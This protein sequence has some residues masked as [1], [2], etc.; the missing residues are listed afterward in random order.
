MTMLILITGLPGTGKTTLAKALAEATGTVHFNSDMIREEL[1]KKG[2]YR[3]QTKALIY[4]E[5]LERTQAELTT[6][7]TVIVDA[8]FSLANARVAFEAVAK[9]LKTPI[10]WIQIQADEQ[11]IKARVSQRRAHSEADFVVYNK[12]K[13]EYQPLAQHH[14][15]LWST[16]DN[17]KEMVRKAMYYLSLTPKS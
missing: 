11:Q 15:V 2:D 7:N 14:I 4:Q 3:P 1:G 6:G 16:N 17:L 8:T 10:E 9:K 5:M 13:A 12:I